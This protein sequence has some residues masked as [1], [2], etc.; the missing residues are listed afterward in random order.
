MKKGLTTKNFVLIALLTALYVVVTFVAMM[1][2]SV[3]GAFGHAISPGIMGLL[4]G[5][6][7][8]FMSR[9]VGKMWQFT[10]M[11]AIIMAVSALAGGAYLPWLI[12]SMLGAVIADFIASREEKPSVFKLALASAFIHVGSAMGAVIPSLFFAKQYFEEWVKRGQTPE[13]MQQMM[14]ATQGFMALV[15]TVLNA[16][17]AFAGVYIGWFILRKHLKEN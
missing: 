15:G 17:L 2:T 16:G 11:V 8:V 9:K 10:I 6:I 12:S 4:S 1:L 13:Q 7:I 14:S 5:A 3:F